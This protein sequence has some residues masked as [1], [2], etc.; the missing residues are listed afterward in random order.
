M[1]KRN[2]FNG[3]PPSVLVHCWSN[4]QKIG[5]HFADPVAVERRVRVFWGKT[6]TGKSRRAWSEAG[7]NAYPKDPRSKFWDGYRGQDNV[8]IGNFN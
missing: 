7:L 8:V 3:I 4:L 2:E 6:G 1:A 5:A